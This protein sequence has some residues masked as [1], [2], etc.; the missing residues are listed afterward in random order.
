MAGEVKNMDQ[1]CKEYLEKEWN[2]LRDNGID[3]DLSQ[4]LEEME[5]AVHEPIESAVE[6]GVTTYI[7]QWISMLCEVCHN[8]L[9]D[10]KPYLQQLM[11]SGVTEEIDNKRS[12]VW[13]LWGGLME[14]YPSVG[15]SRRE[16]DGAKKAILAEL[17]SLMLPD[18]YPS[19][20]TSISVGKAYSEVIYTKSVERRRSYTEDLVDFSDKNVNSLCKKYLEWLRRYWKEDEEIYSSMIQKNRFQKSKI[21]R[22]AETEFFDSYVDLIEKQISLQAKHKM[23]IKRSEFIRDLLSRVDDHGTMM[24]R[25]VH[26]AALEGETPDLPLRARNDETKK[27]LGEIWFLVQTS[28]PE[29]V[30]RVRERLEQ[31]C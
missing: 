1:I 6:S 24:R 12:L 27:L 9:D 25:F 28:Y 15:T 23:L 29:A 8:N 14:L 16:L 20:G 30:P 2:Y 31:E 7:C 22:S 3:A 5:T 19:V 17:P 10:I 26:M 4:I 18:L 13:L 21:K 11:S